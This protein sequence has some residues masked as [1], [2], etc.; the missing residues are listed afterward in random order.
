LGRTEPDGIMVSVFSSVLLILATDRGS[1]LITLNG[2][3]VS[4][5]LTEE[6]ARQ[7]FV[8]M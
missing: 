1:R 4:E 7:V 6:Q 2:M 5:E 3:K 8:S